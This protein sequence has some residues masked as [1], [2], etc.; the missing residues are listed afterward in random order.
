MFEFISGIGVGG[1]LISQ[2]VWVHR[3]YSHWFAEG[4]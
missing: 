3:L 2:P 4:R 1:N